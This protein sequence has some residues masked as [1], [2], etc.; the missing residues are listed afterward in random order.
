[1]LGICLT[2]HCKLVKPRPDGS[3][4]PRAFQEMGIMVPAA[5]G[6]IRVLD[7]EIR[8]FGAAQ[9]VHVATVL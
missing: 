3:V 7:P 8:A 2:P 5:H 1:M 6:G 4:L 9:L